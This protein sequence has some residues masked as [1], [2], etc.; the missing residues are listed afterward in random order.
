MKQLFNLLFVTCL[1]AFT[2][3]CS[4][5]NGEEFEATYSDNITIPEA[6][7]IEITIMELINAHRIKIGLNTLNHNELIKGQAFSHT[8]YMIVNN[9]V[10]HDNFYSRKYYLQDYENAVQVA[11]NVAYG[12]SNAESVVNAWLNSDGH[13]GNVEGDFTDFDVSAEKDEQGK[14]YFTNIF[15]KK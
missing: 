10:S 3:S 1:L 12:Y 7:T 9:N 11:E 13:R 5:D 14:W 15:I 6:K 4:T 8:D 2:T